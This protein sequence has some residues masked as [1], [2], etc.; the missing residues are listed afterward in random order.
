[1]TNWSLS[2]LTYPTRVMFKSSKVIPVMLAS[3]VIAK[4]RYSIGEYAAAFLLVVGITMFTL[5]D[6]VC[7]ATWG[8]AASI[9]NALPCLAVGEGVVEV[10]RR[11]LLDCFTLQFNAICQSDIMNRGRVLCTPQGLPTFNF[12]GVVLVLMGVVA[13]AITCNYEETKFFHGHKC[14]QAEVVYYSSLLGLGFSVITLW[15]A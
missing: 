6:K 11:L 7:A 4:R 1:M 2:Y 12:L 13:D 15:G 14:S 10:K 3:V 8:L 9:G 5:A